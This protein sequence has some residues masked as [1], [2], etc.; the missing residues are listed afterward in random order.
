MFTPIDCVFVMLTIF[1]FFT[2]FFSF[3]WTRH[4]VGESHRSRNL[5]GLND[6]IIGDSI[7]NNQ[8][9]EWPAL[10]LTRS[11]NSTNRSTTNVS[12]EHAVQTNCTQAAIL[13]LPSD[14][15]TRAERQ[16]GWIVIHLLL[17]CYC[18]WL[19]ATICDDYFVPAIETMCSCEYEF[20]YKFL[21]LS[22][23]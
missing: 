22:Q 21:L 8:S 19:L 17:A 1:F 4:G 18:F 3:P 14:G 5:L 9:T 12:S 20:K 10:D 15:L 23:I 13:E 6:S 2:L 11:I 7:N 16:R